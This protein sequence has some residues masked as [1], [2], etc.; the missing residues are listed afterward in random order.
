MSDVD[1]IA[2]A[3]SADTAWTPS[4]PS[5]RRAPRSDARVANEPAFVLHA[6]PYK[7]TS[8][9]LDALTR[10]HGRVGLVA[11]GAKRP[12]STLRGLLLA[13]RPLTI[14]WLVGR[15]RLAP[16]ASGSSTGGEL[17]TLTKAE[18]V[19]GLR[20]LDGEALMSGFYLNELLQKLLARD[21]P[22][23]RL[24]EAYVDALTAL[25]R[26]DAP[27]P[28]LRRFEVAL[29]RET[30]YAMRFDQTSSGATIEP[31]ARYRYLPEQGPTRIEARDRTVDVDGW[32]FG[33]T[34]LDMG[35][36]EWSD[37]ATL[38]Q[39]KQLM[40]ELLGHHLAGQVLQTRRFALDLQS[41]EGALAR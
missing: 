3:A 22:H 38:A 15:A 37:P 17:G 9:V 19:G 7:E 24:F 25:A 35:A 5:R 16:G 34:L 28:V 32:V 23:E 4:I 1:D 30:G 2:V 11:R 39:A 18:W 14:D 36:D 29:L 13:F 6:Y 40:R 10:H 26:D 33:K 41:L 20:P 27:A 8:L 12:R 21:D 31:D